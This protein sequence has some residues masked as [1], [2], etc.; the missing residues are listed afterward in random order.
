MGKSV[1][2]LKRQHIYIQ[3]YRCINLY[4]YIYS[5]V[6]TQVCTIADTAIVDYLYHLPT[7][8]NK[9]PFICCKRKTERAYY[10]CIYIYIYIYTHIYLLHMYAAFQAVIQAI[11]LNPFTVCSSRKRKFVDEKIC[12]GR[13]PSNSQKSFPGPG[14]FGCS[15]WTHVPEPEFLKILKLQLKRLL[16]KKSTFQ[17]EFSNNLTFH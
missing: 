15:A 10:V 16:W 9:L 5:S 7:K 1:L 14:R 6:L 3:I 8:E 12:F 4:I 2:L 17:K 13:P 11:F